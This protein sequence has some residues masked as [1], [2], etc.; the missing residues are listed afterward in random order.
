M[1]VGL[2]TDAVAYADLQ[3]GQAV[4]HVDFGEHEALDAAHLHRL[5]HEGGVEPSAAAAAAGDGAELMAA[6]AKHGARFVGEFGGERPR[7]DAG[8]VGLGDPEDEAD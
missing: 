3:F 2:S 8:A 1:T 6:V 7:A 5:A 4:E